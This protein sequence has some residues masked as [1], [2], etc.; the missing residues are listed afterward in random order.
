MHRLTQ[1]PIHKPPSNA[2]EDG[3]DLPA[4]GQLTLEVHSVI[5]D[6]DKSESFVVLL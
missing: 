6:F 1:K 4:H 2:Y 5:F 3:N